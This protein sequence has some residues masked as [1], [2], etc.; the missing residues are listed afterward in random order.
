MPGD[1][2]QDAAD[3]ESSGE[4]EADKA[5]LE[6]ECPQKAGRLEERMEDRAPALIP[7]SGSCSS[8]KNNFIEI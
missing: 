8:G 6:S 4:E 7:A 2:H 5:R 1:C 3:Q